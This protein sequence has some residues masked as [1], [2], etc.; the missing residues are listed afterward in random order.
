MNAIIRSDILC[1][2]VWSACVW[3]K[4]FCIFCMALYKLN[5]MHFKHEKPMIKSQNMYFDTFFMDH[6][7]EVNILISRNSGWSSLCLQMAWHLMVPGHLQEQC[8]LLKNRHSLMGEFPIYKS[9]SNI[10][11]S[12]AVSFWGTWG[13]VWLNEAVTAFNYWSQ[14]SLHE[15]DTPCENIQDVYRIM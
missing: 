6:I 10:S 9:H 1:R 15:V 2:W 5:G 14:G 11:V 3:L 7:F 12:I 13:W 4:L 8:W